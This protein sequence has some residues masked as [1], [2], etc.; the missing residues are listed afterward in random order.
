MYWPTKHYYKE[1]RY[2]NGVLVNPTRVSINDYQ[3]EHV[4][5]KDTGTERTK[6]TF[7]GGKL[8]Y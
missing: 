4:T 8:L 7:K 3:S 5:E 1:V 2:M 6:T